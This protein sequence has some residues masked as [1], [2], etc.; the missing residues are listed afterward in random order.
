MEYLHRNRLSAAMDALGISSLLYLLAAGWFIWL[1]GLN[2][3]ALIAAL[4]LGTLLCTARVKWRRHTFERREKALRRRIGAE[5]LL[6]EMLLSE[7]KEAHQAAAKLLANRWPLALINADGDGAICR[8]GQE[9]LLIQCIRMPTEGEL[10]VGDLLSA[11]RAVRKTNA[12]RAILCVLGKASP[13]VL[14]RAEEAV[15]PIRVVQRD[16]LLGLAGCVAPATDAQLVELGQRKR[17]MA[18]QGSAVQRIFQRQKAK[19]YHL[20]GLLLLLLYVLTDV[21]IY[22]VPGMVCLTMSV[23]SRRGRP[24]PELL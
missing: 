20:Y 19:R 14:A 2:P 16:M 12:D 23:L 13:K 11:Q 6:E 3:P 8:Q 22:A 10:S 1:W 5:L 7:A 21:R 24:G 15:V 4:A 18:G 17:R 9:T